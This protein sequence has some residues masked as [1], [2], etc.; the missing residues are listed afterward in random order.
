MFMIKAVEW[1]KAK[2]E[3]PGFHPKMELISL[4]MG[5][6]GIPKKLS[7]IGLASDTKRGENTLLALCLTDALIGSQEGGEE[8]GKW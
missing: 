2:I 6:D 1:V 4:W 5:R 3:P 7:Y 8:R